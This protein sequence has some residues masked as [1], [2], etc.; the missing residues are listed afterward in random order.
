[1]TLIEVD[2]GDIDSSVMIEYIGATSVIN[3]YL[4]STSTVQQK[5]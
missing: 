3:Y 5:T 4:S 1:M 2:S